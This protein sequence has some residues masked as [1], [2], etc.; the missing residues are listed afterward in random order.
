MKRSNRLH[1][2]INK[3]TEIPA[4]SHDIFINND[5]TESSRERK[6]CVL[7]SFPL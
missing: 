5:I 6:N 4:R 7:I 1:S 2:S 3:R